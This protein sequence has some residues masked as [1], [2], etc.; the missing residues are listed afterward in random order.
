MAKKLFNRQVTL[1]V[2]ETEIDKLRISFDITKTLFSEPNQ[3]RITVF[4]LAE[5]T[6]NSINQA[7]II[8]EQKEGSPVLLVA[9]YENLTEELYR[10]EVIKVLHK[11]ESV[12]WQTTINAG[13]GYSSIATTI[14]EKSWKSGVRLNQVANF[15]ISEMGVGK[16]D[17]STVASDLLQKKMDKGYNASGSAAKVLDNISKLVGGSWSIQDDKLIILKNRTAATLSAIVIN[18]E[19]GMVQTPIRTERGINF[20]SLLNPKIKPG[21]FIKLESKN[22]SETSLVVQKVRYTG[23]NWGTQ[24]YCEV[25]ALKLA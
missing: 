3:A 12:D 24:F 11:K 9:G 4:N 20:T 13:D 18:Q 25:E 21:S 10:G 5:A 16:N 19:T 6:R 2:E 7:T 14:V 23:D 1:S 8:G 15:V 17:T 22:I